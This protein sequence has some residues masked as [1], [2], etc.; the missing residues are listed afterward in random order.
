ME[1]YI[2]LINEE[3][4]VPH[5]LSGRWFFP[6]GSGEFVHYQRPALTCYSE[7]HKTLFGYFSI[8]EPTLLRGLFICSHPWKNTATERIYDAELLQNPLQVEKGDRLTVAYCDPHCES[9][10]TIRKP[11]NQNG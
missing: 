2:R 4:G 7:S 8:T 1:R 9:T 11:R 3:G 6:P 5:C 10:L